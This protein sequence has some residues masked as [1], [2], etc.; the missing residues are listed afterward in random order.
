MP[1]TGLTFRFQQKIDM[2]ARPRRIFVGCACHVRKKVPLR[3]SRR[4]ATVPVSLAAPLGR[5][6]DGALRC[7]V[8]IVH[9]ASRT[10]GLDLL[11]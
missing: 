10:I 4:V 9:S 11:T 7:R 3:S 1:G 5:I 6:V 2:K 8:K